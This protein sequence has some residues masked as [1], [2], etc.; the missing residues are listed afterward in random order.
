MRESA[1]EQPPAVE[2]N[3]IT[4][5]LLNYAGDSVEK[6]VGLTAKYLSFLGFIT[7]P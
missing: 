3:K 4:E 6:A 2:L 1:I 5:V 7:H